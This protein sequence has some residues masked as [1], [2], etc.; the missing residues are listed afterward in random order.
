MHGIFLQASG[1]WDTN[2]YVW[3]VPRDLDVRFLQRKPIALEGHRAH[4]L[5]VAFSTSNLIVRFNL[6][7]S[8]ILVMGI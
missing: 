2:V 1:C 6:D 3:Y 5:S 8:T 4:I 7:V